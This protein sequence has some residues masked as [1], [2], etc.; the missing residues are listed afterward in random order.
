MVKIPV[1]TP[2]HR[3]SSLSRGYYDHLEWP[4]GMPEQARKCWSRI[5]AQALGPLREHLKDNLYPVIEP[6]SP[7]EQRLAEAQEPSDNLVGRL[8]D[9]EVSV[10][11]RLEQLKEFASTW[12]S[13]MEGMAELESI[14]FKQKLEKMKTIRESHMLAAGAAAH[15]ATSGSEQAVAAPTAKDETSTRGREKALG[16]QGARLRTV[17]PL[18]VPVL[19]GLGANEGTGLVPLEVLQAHSRSS[20]GC[21]IRRMTPDAHPKWR[22][23]APEHPQLQ[24]FRPASVHGAVT[25]Q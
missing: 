24:Q 17:S 3:T 6:D 11:K 16:A 9:L 13:A 2:P 1:V 10:G 4:V 12:A 25:F 23:L 7:A 21:I 18:M 5:L 20:N 19:W 8:T 15:G 14:F 22:L